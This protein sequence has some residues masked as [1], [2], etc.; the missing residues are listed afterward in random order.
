MV[1]SRRTKKKGYKD[2]CAYLLLLTDIS[3]WVSTA[4]VELR[5]S[6]PRLDSVVRFGESAHLV[7]GLGSRWFGEQQIPTMCIETGHH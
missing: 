4:D 1:F 2:T 3:Y 7:G 5:A 6:S